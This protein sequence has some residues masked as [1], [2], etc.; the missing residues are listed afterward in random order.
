MLLTSPKLKPIAEKHTSSQLEITDEGEILW[1]GVSLGRFHISDKGYP[2]LHSGPNR[3][4]YVHRCLAAI[5]IG[6]P[7]E[8]TEDVHHND[9]D[10]LNFAPHNLVLLDHRQHGYVSALQSWYL[11]HY[12]EPQRRLFFDEVNGLDATLDDETSVDISFDIGAF[13]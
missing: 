7:L 3:G 6:R 2:R 4:Q 10:K 13:T 5:C 1:R 8:R 12:V 9:N 11:R